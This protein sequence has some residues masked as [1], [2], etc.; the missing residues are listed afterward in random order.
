MLESRLLYF[1]F[2]REMVPTDHT[3]Q[4]QLLKKKKEVGGGFNKSWRS[5]S[6]KTEKE[7]FLIFCLT[8]F[9]KMNG[10]QAGWH[11][12]SSTHKNYNKRGAHC[13]NNHSA[14]P[15]KRFTGYL[16]IWRDSM[17]AGLQWADLSRWHIQG[18]RDPWKKKENSLPPL[19]VAK[20]FLSVVNWGRVVGN[21]RKR[22][23]T[24]ILSLQFGVLNTEFTVFKTFSYKT[25]SLILS[26]SQN[27]LV[28]R[29][30][31]SL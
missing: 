12:K 11:T 13:S 21:K 26:F 27:N 10:T 28:R 24:N 17:L 1:H 31:K 5:L 18:I 6:F 2:Q 8:H 15:L 25:L 23:G 3:T 29:I 7:V 4:D 9:F 16:C 22:T 30:S 19:C 14:S 20:A